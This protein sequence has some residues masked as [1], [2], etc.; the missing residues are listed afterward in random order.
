MDESKPR[1]ARAGGLGPALKRIAPSRP[2][3]HSCGV[4]DPPGRDRTIAASSDRSTIRTPS[5]LFMALRWATSASISYLCS[6][7]MASLTRQSS[8]RISSGILGYSH[9]LQ[10]RAYLR[11]RMTMHDADA[12]YN[13]FHL[14]IID[15]PAIP[16]QKKIHA[17]H[18]LSLKQSFGQAQ[19]GICDRKYRGMRRGLKTPRRGIGVASS[20][21]LHRDIRSV[22][23]E[24]TSVALPPVDG[25]FLSCRCK[26]IARRPDSQVRHDRGLDV[27]ALSVRCHLRFLAQRSVLHFM[28]SY[29]AGTAI[30]SSSLERSGVTATLCRLCAC[31][32]AQAGRTPK[33]QYPTQLFKNGW[34]SCIFF[35]TLA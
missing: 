29:C 3:L 31:E 22:E 23:A 21:F 9:K 12:S 20:S 35:A 28:I 4:H 32:Q 6:R 24:S 5:G 16:T 1:P 8:W 27:D 17:M 25:C 2:Y 10:R 33:P 7:A 30:A 26:Q 13:R 14:G 11:R 19:D 34:I 18:R 15:V